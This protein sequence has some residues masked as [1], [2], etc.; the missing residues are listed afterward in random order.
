MGDATLRLCLS[1]TG[2][3]AYERRVYRRRD[4]RSQQAGVRCSDGAWAVR[5]LFGWSGEINTML[6]GLGMLRHVH[7]TM[8]LSISSAARRHT[9]FSICP[10]GNEGRYE[11]EGKHRQQQ[12]G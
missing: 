3:M 8:V 10:Q 7:Q 12:N 9:R 5:A 11:W 1:V 4:P 2:G 6:S